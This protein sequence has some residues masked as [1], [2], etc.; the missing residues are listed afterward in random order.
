IRALWHRNNTLPVVDHGREQTEEL[1][2]NGER[3]TIPMYRDSWRPVIK[4]EDREHLRPELVRRAGFRDINELV[5]W[6]LYN[7]TGGGLMAELGSHQL[8]ASSI[9]LG[10]VHPI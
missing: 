4:P 3:H 5:R 7:R 10:K 8:D 2:V 1:T 6:R 9:F